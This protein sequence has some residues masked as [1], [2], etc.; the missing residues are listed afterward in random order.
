MLALNS[1]LLPRDL[2]VTLSSGTVKSFTLEGDSGRV[3]LTYHWD[4]A[5]KARGFTWV[6]VD[7]AFDSQFAIA[8]CA[9]IVILH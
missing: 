7:T 8:F 6:L 3:P 1:D 4:V 2:I 9:T 5:V